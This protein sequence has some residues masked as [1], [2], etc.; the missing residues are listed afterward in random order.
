M[1]WDTALS[2]LRMVLSDGPTDKLR[3]RKMVIGQIDGS[4]TT[5]KTFE[6]RRVSTFVGAVAPAG[7]YVNNALVT[8]EGEDLE[9]GEFTLAAPPNEGDSIVATYYYQWFIDA[10]LTE[11]LNQSAAFINNTTDFTAIDPSFQPAAKEYA[12]GLAYQKLAAKFAENLA[13]VF[14]LQDAP[15][16]KRFNPVTA[17]MGIAEKKFKL[18]FELRDD[19]YTGRKGQA[20]APRSA[21]IRGHVKDV[22]PNR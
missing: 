17:Y 3:Y 11:F 20:G 4:N 14:Q 18:A 13:E 15:D 1:S 19:V 21:T 10:E 8:T 6:M 5:F 9:S 22:A 12:A 2:E 16:Q 7:V